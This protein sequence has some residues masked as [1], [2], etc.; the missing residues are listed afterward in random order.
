MI[1][2]V[3]GVALWLQSLLSNYASLLSWVSVWG[4]LGKSLLLSSQINQSFAHEFG[5]WKWKKSTACVYVCV[6][7]CVMLMCMTYLETSAKRKMHHNIGNCLQKGMEGD[8]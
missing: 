1:I 2:I 4:T 5:T 8:R 7:V 6:E 3:A